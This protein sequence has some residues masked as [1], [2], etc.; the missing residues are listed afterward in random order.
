MTVAFGP[1]LQSQ[2]LTGSRR[3]ASNLLELGAVAMR[4]RF[5]DDDRL[6]TR[7]LAHGEAASRSAVHRRLP[8]DSSS[9]SASALTA[10]L[11]LARGICEAVCEGQKMV[12]VMMPASVAG[13]SR[14]IA[15]TLAGKTPVNLNFTVGRA[16]MA[17]TPSAAAV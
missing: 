17:S 12:G 3:E 6:H 4:E 15:V 16:A 7:F 10:S 5:T 2:A 1:P 11:L 8:P 14:N 9:R 13:R